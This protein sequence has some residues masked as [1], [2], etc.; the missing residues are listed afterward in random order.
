MIQKGND[1]P[2]LKYI[3]NNQSK[4]FWQFCNFGI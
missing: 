4:W 3:F 2:D 1:F